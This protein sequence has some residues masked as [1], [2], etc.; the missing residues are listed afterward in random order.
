MFHTLGG[1]ADFRVPEIGPHLV[2]AALGTPQ[3]TSHVP[4][5]SVLLR[6]RLRPTALVLT[7]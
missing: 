6:G 2:G 4:T 3:V 1:V 7:S 5:I